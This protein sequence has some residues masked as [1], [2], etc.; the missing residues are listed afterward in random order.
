MTSPGKKYTFKTLK[1]KK[2]K[3]LRSGLAPNITPPKSAYNSDNILQYFYRSRSIMV[4]SLVMVIF[5][6]FVAPLF[7]LGERRRA[8]GTLSISDDLNPT[9]S[10]SES[11][12]LGRIPF[13]RL[14]RSENNA[15][16]CSDVNNYNINPFRDCDCTTLG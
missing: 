8:R 7:Q 16:H 1:G 10:C 4:M 3:N 5:R 15:R 6:F 13:F 14:I 11:L 2:L 9:L 12:G